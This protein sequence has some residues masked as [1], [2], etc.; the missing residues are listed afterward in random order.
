MNR[1]VLIVF[2]LFFIVGHSQILDTIQE[3]VFSQYSSQNTISG[4]M[5]DFN[6]YKSSVDSSATRIVKKFRSVDL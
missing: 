6:Y 2:Q 4:I 3:N 5:T 1:K